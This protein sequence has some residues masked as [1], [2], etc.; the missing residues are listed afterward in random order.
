MGKVMGLN[1][2]CHSLPPQT[3]ADRDVE[4]ALKGYGRPTEQELL[5]CFAE[6]IPLTTRAYT[7][8]KKWPLSFKPS[9]VEPKDRLDVTELRT[10][11]NTYSH[12]YVDNISRGYPFLY[13][14][15]MCRGRDVY[16]E[17]Y[18]NHTTFGAN[19]RPYFTWLPDS[20]PASRRASTRVA[21]WAGMLSVGLILALAWFFL[22][23]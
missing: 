1:P 3:F 8:N 16:S 19:A 2:F 4:L 13:N 22:T 10:L 11:W 7:A 15:R 5:F 21:M 17:D 23:S 6:I 12:Q 20:P 14:P 9:F 18:A